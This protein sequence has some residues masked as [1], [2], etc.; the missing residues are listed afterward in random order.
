MNDLL[1][2]LNTYKD[3]F[4]IAIS[5]LSLLVTLG[6]STF[7]LN[8]LKKDT[9]IS[10]KNLLMR[11]FY[12]DLLVNKS[13]YLS[14]KIFSSKK[15]KDFFIKNLHLF[16]KHSKMLLLS[17]LESEKSNTYKKNSKEKEKYSLTKNYFL[18]T[19]LNYIYNFYYDILSTEINFNKSE[20]ILPP[21]FRI[22]FRLSIFFLISLFGTAI[23]LSGAKNFFSYISI[24]A[25]I[26]LLLNLLT[27][28]I[29]KSKT[30][31]SNIFIYIYPKYLSND[32][33]LY[34]VL[35]KKNFNAYAG[36][37]IACPKNHKLSI[38]IKTEKL[39]CLPLKIFVNFPNKTI[40]FCKKITNILK[41]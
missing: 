13:T 19:H 33:E 27:K 17:I 24:W 22:L 38:F 3:L 5:F 14:Q 40:N 2:F 15:R 29:Y 37:K 23:L 32:E 12:N 7:N 28:A 20:W 4:L 31:S 39:E 11:D 34:C 10:N 6:I 9:S 25:I 41:R 1:N 8:K 36:L 35:C 30:L 26:F 18:N 16:D 21:F